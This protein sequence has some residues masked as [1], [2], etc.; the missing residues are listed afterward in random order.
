MNEL[1][2]ILKEVSSDDS[3]SSLHPIQ[4]FHQC[5]EQR[6]KKHTCQNLWM[7]QSCVE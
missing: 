2:A 1:L 7:T 4:Y 6:Y 5:L 3:D